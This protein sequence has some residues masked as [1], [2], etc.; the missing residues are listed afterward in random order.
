MV[1]DLGELATLLVECLV[2]GRV[3]LEFGGLGLGVRGEVRAKSGVG[4]QIRCRGI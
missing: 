1:S 3:K 2:T 4:R